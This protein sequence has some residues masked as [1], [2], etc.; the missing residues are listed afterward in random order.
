MKK[1]LA[2]LL[3]L[4]ILVGCSSPATDDKKEEGKTDEKTTE[5]AKENEKKEDNK[6]AEPTVIDVF[7]RDS[8]S[9]TREAFEGGIKLEKDTLTKDAVET[10]GNGDMAAKVGADEK[11][12]GYVSLT[13]DMEA[14]NLKPLSFEG[15]EPTIEKVLDNSY[16][17]SRPFSYVTRAAGDFE[18]EEKEKVVHAFLD[19][20]HNSTEGLEAV[21]GA[22]GIV[23]KANAKAW[24][25]LKANHPVLEGDVTAITINTAGSTSVEKTLKAALEAFQGL[26]G[27]QF[28][29]NQTGSGDGY[30]R[31]LG[32]EKDGANAADIGFASRKF[33]DDGSEDVTKAL[34]SGFYC[35]DAVV[36][37]V[38]K[39][40]KVAPEN[41][42]AEQVVSIFNGTVKNWED[43]K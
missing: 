2:L 37:V 22:G 34:D 25:E 11:A 17:L 40:N 24:D 39:D 36:V 5:V 42:T 31:V 13:T 23:D 38:S 20:L 43:I 6:A 27:V 16:T 32:G 12:I 29:M 9:G 35:L 7:T 33:K 19:F 21:E 10:S 3:A 8:T 1:L 4:L 41:M 18:S 30:K 14:N 15:V 28:A 26:T